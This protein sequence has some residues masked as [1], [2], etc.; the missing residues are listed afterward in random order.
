MPEASTLIRKHVI[1][2]CGEHPEWSH[3]RIARELDAI[4]PD[5]VEDLFVSRHDYM[6]NQWVNGIVSE[7]RIDQRNRLKSGE[8]LEAISP[9]GAGKLY[10]LADMSGVKVG[11]L[12]KL[13]MAAGSRLTKVGEFDVHIGGEAGRK[14]IKS[15]FDESEL[16][17]IYERFTGGT[18]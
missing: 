18:G 10:R 9:D 2:M 12:G 3:S 15:V 8:I 7:Y 14:K 4:W 17:T 1:A 11:E 13:Y 16:R 6:L 5:L